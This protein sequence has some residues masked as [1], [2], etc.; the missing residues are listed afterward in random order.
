MSHLIRG[1]FD[2]DGCIYKSKTICKGKEY[3]YRYISF[4]SGSKTFV[5]DLSNFL[6]NINIHFVINEDSRRKNNINKTYYIK[7]YKEKDVLKL[8]NLMYENCDE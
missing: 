7:I 8:K 2:G 5:N 6:T 1:I 3:M 4:T